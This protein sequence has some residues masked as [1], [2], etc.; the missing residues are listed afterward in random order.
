MKIVLRIA[1]GTFA[2]VAAVVGA[3]I[4]IA[5]PAS[6]AAAAAPTFRSGPPAVAAGQMAVFGHIKTLRPKGRGYL[7]RFDPAWFTS[8]VTASAAAA[9]DGAGSPGQPVPNDNYV[10]EE[11]HRL[12]AYL[13]P[14]T[15]RV[16]VLTKGPVSTPVTV[17]ELAR[18]VNG[19][20]HLRLFEQLDT[21]VWVVVR[22]DTVRS[23]DQQYH[24]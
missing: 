17:A 22:V 5:Q 7:M 20:K 24:P 1:A 15:A 10:V 12:L 6:S 16:T 8:G 13:V 4:L 9:Q 23:I 18:I 19:G 11:G 21:G 2:L 14:R 3:A